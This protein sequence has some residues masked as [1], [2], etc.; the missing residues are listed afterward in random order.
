MLVRGGAHTLLLR[1]MR[2][3]FLST[4]VII[5]VWPT[6][7]DHSKCAKDTPECVYFNGTD[8]IADK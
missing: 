4:Q 5:Y 3:A 8:T 2:L 6:P 7:E 1:V